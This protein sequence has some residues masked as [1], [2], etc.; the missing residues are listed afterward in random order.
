MI[1]TLVTGP[2]C[3]GKSCYVQKMRG[4]GDIVFD[5]DALMIA[6]GSLSTHGHEK[7][8]VALAVTGR[9]AALRELSFRGINANVWYISCWPSAAEN[10]LFP[11]IMNRVQMTATIEECKRW[12][13]DSGRPPIYQSLINQWFSVHGATL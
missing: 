7:A 4:E 12:A 6:F 11:R 2:P 8:Y 3:S 9:I 10:G 5:L 13:I 1:F